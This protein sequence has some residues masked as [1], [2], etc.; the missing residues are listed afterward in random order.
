MKVLL[1]GGAG[2]IGKRY[3]AILR[4]L[5]ADCIILD[6]EGTKK[7]TKEIITEITHLRCDRAII[8][9]PTH[10]HYEYAVALL[11]LRI[12]FLCEKPLS[13]NLKE[14]QHLVELQREKEVLAYVVNN[15]Q[16]V[17][18]K[19]GS[20]IVYDYFYHGRDEPLWDCCQLIYLDP[21]AEINNSSAVWLL[22]NHHRRINYRD[23]EVSYIEMVEAFMAD[24]IPELW[25][26]QQGMD[27]TEAVYRRARH[28]G[29]GWNSSAE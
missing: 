24:L 28:E 27:M 19:T 9:S 18:D 15:Y 8:A 26:L 16:F 7:T 13:K 2:S 25:T 1:I 29:L 12:P 23:L 20:K 21:K 3:R 10:T 6:P 17:L 5:G 11:N 4:Y 14:C 22:Y